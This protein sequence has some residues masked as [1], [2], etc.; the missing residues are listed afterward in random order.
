VQSVI[1]RNFPAEAARQTTFCIHR[2]IW[3]YRKSRRGTQTYP[4]FERKR[5]VGKI[6]Y[7]ACCPDLEGLVAKPGR[8]AGLGLLLVMN[9]RGPRFF[10]EYRKDWQVPVAEAGIQIEFCPYCGRNLADLFP[11]SEGD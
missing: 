2:R 4:L 10:L 1:E 6:N 11:P 5:G 3:Q 8:E 9:K 7:A